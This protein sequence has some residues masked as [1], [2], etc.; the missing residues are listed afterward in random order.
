[1]DML[2]ISHW[3]AWAAHPQG[4]ITLA[5]LSFLQ[6]ILAA[7]NLV[8]VAIVSQGLRGRRRKRAQNIGFALALALRIAMLL[9]VV[10]VMQLERPVLQLFGQDIS[11]RD[12]LMI[13]GGLY[14]MFKATDDMHKEATYAPRASVRLRA[15]GFFAVVLAVA[16]LDAVFSLDSLL[17][18]V[19]MTQNMP[20]L[21][22]SNVIAILA[23]ITIAYPVSLFI[24]RHMTFRLLA[25]SYVLLMGLV[26]VAEGLHFHIP[27][28]Y[29]YFAMLFSL[30]TEAVNTWVRRRRRRHRKLSE[31]Q[32]EVAGKISRGS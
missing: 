14:L 5:T 17:A 20:I 8:V 24:E 18:S 1:M 22:L 23:M 9:G 31:L 30:L 13:C 32:G 27:R 2:D 6:I 28:G 7:D 25:L 10:W 19:A 26:L 11:W 29:V 21:I 16:A 3:L 12:I 4:W 15:K